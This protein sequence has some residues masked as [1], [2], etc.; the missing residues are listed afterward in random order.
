MN[1]PRNAKNML[2]K[3]ENMLEPSKIRIV[4]KEISISYD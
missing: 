3:K 4:W 2:K 1:E